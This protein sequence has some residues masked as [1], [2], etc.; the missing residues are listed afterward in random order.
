MGE[1]KIQCSRKSTKQGKCAIIIHCLCKYIVARE[2]R[3]AD[4]SMAT[5]SVIVRLVDT[6]SEATKEG[7][8]HTQRGLLDRASK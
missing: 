7:S 4:T 2:E 1:I 3:E 8:Q 6:T 5:K